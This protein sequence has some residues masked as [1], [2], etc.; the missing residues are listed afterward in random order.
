MAFAEA[1]KSNTTLE[2]LESADLP[3]N[4]PARVSRSFTALHASVYFTPSSSLR[5]ISTAAPRAPPSN[6]TSHSLSPVPHAHSPHTACTYTRSTLLACRRAI[7][8]AA[9]T[10][11]RATPRGP[12]PRPPLPTGG[13]RAR[14]H[15]P[16]CTCPSQA[17]VQ[18]PRRRRRAGPQSGRPQRPQAGALAS[19][20]SSFDTS[21]GPMAHA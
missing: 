21:E 12:R 15:P 1:L 9:A 6:A 5:S 16:A 11:A 8:L 3:S 14:L 7:T 20:R 10:H 19:G 17:G 13:W 18:R 4:P 2:Y